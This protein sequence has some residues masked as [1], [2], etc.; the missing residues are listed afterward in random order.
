MWA[1]ATFAFGLS[2]A[3][4]GLM[5]LPFFLVLFLFGIAMGIFG[6]GTVLRFGPASEWFVWPLPALVSPFAGVFYPIATLPAW[7]QAVSH[8]VPASYVFE[9][10]RGRVGTGAA[11]N[12]N[13]VW[14]LALAIVYLALACW[15]FAHVYRRAVR[16]GLLARYSAESVN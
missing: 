5:L 2:Y 15:Y 8:L 14:G 16:T 10:M 9:W 4:F 6:S 13:L 7:M 3:G 12:T 1:I 11:S